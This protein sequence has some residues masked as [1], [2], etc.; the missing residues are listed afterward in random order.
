MCERAKITW[1]ENKTIYTMHDTCC[2]KTKSVIGKNLN[3]NVLCKFLDN[4]QF[5]YSHH[6]IVSP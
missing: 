1:A 6:D 2:H 5:I 4:G 3:Q